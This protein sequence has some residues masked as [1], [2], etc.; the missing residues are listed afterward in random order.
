MSKKDVG[1]SG[2]QE[3]RPGA[4]SL[5]ETTL[6]Q[7]ITLVWFRRDLRLADNPALWYSSLQALPVYILEEDERDGWPH[8]SAARWWLHHSLKALAASLERLGLPL[9]LRRGDPA[10]LLPE[11]A[12]QCGAQTV[13]WNRRYDPAGIQRDKR[14]TEQIE[15]HS[16]R[17]RQFKANLVFEPGDLRPPDGGSCYK[18]FERFWKRCLSL[19]GHETGYPDKPLATPD[20][21]ERHPPPQVPPSDSLEDW[22]LCAHLP[23]WAADLGKYWVPGEDGARAAWA[24]FLEKHSWKSH[25]TRD[26]PHA[27]GASRLSPH[28]S[29]GEISTRS[30]WV[31]TKITFALHRDK[32]GYIKGAD[33]FLRQLVW[34]EFTHQLLYYH[35]SLPESSHDPGFND[36]PWREDPGNLERWQQGQTGYPLVD[37]GLRQLLRTGY[38]HGR[39]RILTASFLTRNLL[40]PW[41]LGAEWF[42]EHLVDANLANNSFGW[43]WVVGCSP[44]TSPRTEVFNPVDQSLRLDPNGDYIRDWVP[45]LN[46]LPTKWLHAPWQA[47]AEVLREAGVTLGEDYPAPIVDHEQRHPEF[48]VLYKT[49]KT[50]PSS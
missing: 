2:S 20:Y 24:P 48:K 39:L 40:I 23:D 15:K 13:L 22:K 34:R 28:I 19:A 27:P 16:I 44:C 37:A 30:V 33:A 18:D 35:P 25:E 36:L 11:L 46:A 9:L 7:E 14:V 42:W 41:R 1:P 10:R 43:Q 50:R 5:L 49:R 32:P 8:G 4:D 6:Q 47:P 3:P 26:F 29:F 21:I 12:L 38:M 17:S 45:E 31:A